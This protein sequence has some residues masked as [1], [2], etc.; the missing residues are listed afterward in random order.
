MLKI[1]N[2]VDNV[3]LDF[4]DEVL[5]YKT[6]EL[7]SDEQFAIFEEMITEHYEDKYA[8]MFEEHRDNFSDREIVFLEHTMVK[9]PMLGYLLLK[10]LAKKK[11]EVNVFMKMFEDSS[12]KLSSIEQESL[13]ETARLN[14]AAAYDKLIAL[15]EGKNNMFN[16]YHQSVGASFSF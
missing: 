3:V 7:L 16:L 12:E 11:K 5:I 14:P 10:T 4:G 2:E 1:T 15:V 13:A 8:K 6:S 9:N